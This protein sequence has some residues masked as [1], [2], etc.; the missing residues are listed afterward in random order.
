MPS[1]HV[2]SINKVPLSAPRPLFVVLLRD[3]YYHKYV[4]YFLAL[5]GAVAR[6]RNMLVLG[7]LHNNVRTC[8]TPWYN[9]LV[10]YSK[11]SQQAHPVFQ[12]S[13]TRARNILRYHVCLS[14]G[15]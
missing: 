4:I 1:V 15:W 7:P 5:K 14:L 3:A 9:L 6:G 10:Q 11:C 13:A 12:R 8:A 2:F